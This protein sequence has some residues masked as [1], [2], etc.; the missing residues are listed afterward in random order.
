M[1]KTVQ[2]KYQADT[3]SAVKN[4]EKLKD[5]IDDVNQEVEK[6]ESNFDEVG[7]VIDGFTGGAVSGFRNVLGSVKGLSGG[8]KGLK[9]AIISTGIGALITSKTAKKEQRCL[10]LLA[11][12]WMVYSRCLQIV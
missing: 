6:S 1:S 5:S 11:M 9:G 3:D 4:V 10:R 12:L 8:M 2:I 7:G